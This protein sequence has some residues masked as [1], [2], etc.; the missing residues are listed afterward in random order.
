MNRAFWE[1][2]E[3]RKGRKGSQ[4]CDGSGVTKCGEVYVLVEGGEG[5]KNVVCY[6]MKVHPCYPTCLPAAGHCP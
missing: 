3:V 6:A 1:E 2:C 5:L 4:V